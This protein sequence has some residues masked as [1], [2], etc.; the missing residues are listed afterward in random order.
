M[1][2]AQQQMVMGIVRDT[3]G[4]LPSAAVKL[5]GETDR[6]FGLSDASGHFAVG[7]VPNGR[8][9]LEVQAS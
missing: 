7:P 9:T 4:P 6:F 1:L 8:Y 5:L 2:C 3:E